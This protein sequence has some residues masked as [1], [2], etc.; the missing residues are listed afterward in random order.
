MLGE[1]RAPTVTEL[2]E[3]GTKLKRQM[4]FEGGVLTPPTTAA[5]TTLASGTARAPPRTLREGATGSC[6]ER[7]QL[8]ARLLGMQRGTCHKWTS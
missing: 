8:A 6:V 5:H 7:V 1:Y 4:A 2:R 3:L